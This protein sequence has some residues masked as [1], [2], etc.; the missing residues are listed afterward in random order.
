MYPFLEH[1]FW[2]LNYW[3]LF[4]FSSVLLYRNMINHIIYI[5]INLL[6]SISLFQVCGCRQFGFLKIVRQ[7]LKGSSM[8]GSLTFLVAALNSSIWMRKDWRQGLLQNCTILK[9]YPNGNK[10]CCKRI[11]EVSL[12]SFR[13]IS[14]K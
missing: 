5:P 2:I 9:I 12:V 7:I 13:K 14:L 1:G 8:S 3:T 6:T 10:L 11:A 4:L